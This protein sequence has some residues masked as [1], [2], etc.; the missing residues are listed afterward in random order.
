MVTTMS[1]RELRA[2]RERLGL[3]QAELAKVVGVQRV[4]VA[5][6]EAG[7]RKIPPMLTLALKALRKERRKRSK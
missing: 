7:L 6:W 5:R 3:T 4:T 2:A 1:G